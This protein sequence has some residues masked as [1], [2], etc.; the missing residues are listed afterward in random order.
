MI[1]RVSSSHSLWLLFLTLFM[2]SC[3]TIDKT[4]GDKLIPTDQDL[5]L[6]TATFD[7]PVDSRTTG[8]LPTN[9][10]FFEYDVEM[11]LMIGACYNPLF[12]LTE[13]GT[14]FQFFP[15]NSYG[16]GIS[17]GDNLEPVS[18]T[19]TLK[20]QTM[21]NIVLDQNQISIPQNVFVHEITKEITYQNAYNNS[22][23]SQDW[24]P[25]RQISAYNRIYTLRSPPVQDI[26]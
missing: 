18:L 4:M 12:G 8:R 23:L 17:Y 13:A 21:G 19:L 6:Y 16:A 2:C 20:R 3:I 25:P 14:V 5:T 10:F 15:Y 9:N 11:P 7:L 24:N 1:F 22:L 26:Q